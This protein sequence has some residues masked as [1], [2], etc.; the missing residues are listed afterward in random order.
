[1]GGLIPFMS[2]YMAIVFTSAVVT[3]IFAALI[4]ATCA[5]VMMRRWK[6]ERQQ[7]G[8][9]AVFWGAAIVLFVPVCMAY[10]A[11]LAHQGASVTPSEVKSLGPELPTNAIKIN[12]RSDWQ[13][14]DAVFTIKEHQLTLWAKSNRWNVEEIQGVEHAYLSKLSLEVIVERG[15]VIHE[16]FHPRGTGVDVIFNRMTEECFYRYSSY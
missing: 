15:L 12:Y 16:K 6:G 2:V 8:L 13:G 1:M 3:L 5:L 10:F 11:L 14:T 7:K 4:R 9:K